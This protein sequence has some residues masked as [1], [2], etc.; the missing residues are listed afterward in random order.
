MFCCTL[1]YV[2]SSIAIILVGKRELVA[3]LNLPS[4]CLVMVEWL[5]PA[6]PGGCLQL[7]IVVFP[8]HTHYFWHHNK[9]KSKNQEP[10]QS[11]TSPDSGYQ[12]ES[13]K[14]TIRHHKREPRGQPFRVLAVRKTEVWV[15]SYVITERTANTLIKLGGC[16]SKDCSEWV[17][18]TLNTQIRLGVALSDQ[19]LRV[20]QAHLIGI[21][22][23]RLK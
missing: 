1:L 8:N 11:S 13:N 12:W 18:A 17:Y 2:H 5:F 9:K 23:A 7:V 14:L 19:S 4:L 20:A 15:L 10:I 21:V 6:V 16:R 22:T 3:L